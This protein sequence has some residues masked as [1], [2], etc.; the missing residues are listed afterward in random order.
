MRQIGSSHSFRSV[1]ATALILGFT[2]V[3]NADDSEG[4]DGQPGRHRIDRQILLEMGRPDIDT[5]W[6]WN[7]LADGITDG[8]LRIKSKGIQ[9][10]GQFTLRERKVR[11][12]VVGPKFKGGYGLK[13]KFEF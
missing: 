7:W 4:A 13:F 11:F 12:R 8:S 10:R 5:G 6:D 9:Y 2:S 3:A 1:L